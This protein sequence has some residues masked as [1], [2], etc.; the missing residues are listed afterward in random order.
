MPASFKC[1]PS[2]QYLA[3]HSCSWDSQ[4]G[5]CEQTP[6]LNSKRCENWLSQPLGRTFRRHRHEEE[7]YV[8]W[9]GKDD[10]PMISTLHLSLNETRCLNSSWSCL[11][12]E[13]EHL[14]SQNQNTSWGTVRLPSGVAHHRKPWYHE[15]SAFCLPH[16]AM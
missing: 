2:S 15:K 10:R 5:R 4:T 1:S 9:L 12:F 11:S 3:M 6:T 14:F 8:L 7:D 16:H 13:F